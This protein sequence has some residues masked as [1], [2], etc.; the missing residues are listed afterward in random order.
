MAGTAEF[1]LSA[2]RPEDDVAASGGAID[3]TMRLMLRADGDNIA[4][5]GGDE[6]DFVSTAAGDVQNMDVAG[7]KAD[8][9][10]VEEVVALN[11][12]NH[13]QTANEYKH[14][15]KVEF[16]VNA[17]GIIT[18]A[19]FNVGAP[20]LL[21][22]IPVGEQGKAAMFLEAQANPAGGAQKKLYEKFFVCAIGGVLGGAEFYCSEDEDTEVKFDCEED[23]GGNTV[24]DAA[25][26][27]ADRLTEPAVGGGYIW[28]DHATVGA[29][30]TMGDNEDGILINGERQG[31]WIECTLAAG[32]TAEMQVQYTLNWFATS[33]A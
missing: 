8:G 29:A 33:S 17:A 11:G 13:V 32:R 21:F 26:Q 25:E 22:T 23:V 15:R 30:H 27:V 6:I 28:A 19:E 24:T 16:A 1:F 4:G 2:N 5:G 12:T 3:L 18:V 10:W 31:I 14:L 9:S 7:Y 20:I